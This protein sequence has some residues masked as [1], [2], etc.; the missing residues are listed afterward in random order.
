[1]LSWVTSLAHGNRLQIIF[2]NQE[3]LFNEERN[4]HVLS[5]ISEEDLRGWLIEALRGDQVSYRRFLDAASRIARGFLFNR[6]IRTPELE[7]IVQEVLLSIHKA[8]NS[9]DQSAP[10]LPWLFA[11]IQYRLV[12][13][14]RNGSRNL[15]LSEGDSVE[16][17]AE[18][19]YVTAHEERLLAEQ[20]L[21]TMPEREQRILRYLKMEGWSVR[22]ISEQMGISESAVKVYAF[23]AIRALRVKFGGS[24]DEN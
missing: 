1:V 10:V 18:N 16:D 19:S 11:I 23:R 5:R 12:D 22:E 6:G 9:Y 3:G 15:A 20:L 4:K 2:C 8:K 24:S 14:F 13:N 7:D 17:D 21:A